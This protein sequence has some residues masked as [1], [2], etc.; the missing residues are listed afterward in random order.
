MDY[1]PDSLVLQIS[2]WCLDFSDVN[3]ITRWCKISVHYHQLFNPNRT[4][5]NRI[6]ESFT[7]YH[8]PYI[9]KK[10]KCKRWDRYYLYRKEIISLK[11]KKHHKYD[12]N[13]YH[14]FV[15]NQ[16][17]LKVLESRKIS[18]R[19]TSYLDIRL[20]N[21]K[22]KLRQEFIIENCD[23]YLNAVNNLYKKPFNCSI[24]CNDAIDE[25]ERDWQ[26]INK[27]IY[28][29]DIDPKTG[30]RRHVMS[31]KIFYPKIPSELNKRV[32]DLEDTFCPVVMKSQR[33]E[34]MDD[35][36]Y[37]VFNNA[38]ADCHVCHKIILVQ[39][40]LNQL[41]ETIHQGSKERFVFQN[42]NVYS[43]N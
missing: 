10:L 12:K 4:A 7:R 20:L 6:W 32:S 22:A 23:H 43:Y 16:I 38:T 33:I 13:K 9:P 37:K 27:N 17:R 5:A 25:V 41:T 11:F 24:D 2:V 42:V 21:E 19:N 8:F 15:S 35:K 39:P 14:G 29:T 34:S 30:A 26:L 36:T 40:I 1:L 28:S 31:S 18:T 3:S